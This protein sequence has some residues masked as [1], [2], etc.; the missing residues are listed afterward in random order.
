MPVNK[1]KMLNE[2]RTVFQE[3]LRTV[4]SGKQSQGCLKRIAIIFLSLPNHP[5]RWGWL[6]LTPQ[7][8]DNQALNVRSMLMGFIFCIN[9]D[10]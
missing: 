10:K 5:K 7:I 8:A 1:K 4:K 9:D 3:D 2:K 6:A